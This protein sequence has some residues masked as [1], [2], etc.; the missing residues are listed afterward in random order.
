MEMVMMNEGLKGRVVDMAGVVSVYV[1]WIQHLL[2][3]RDESDL[4]SEVEQQVEEVP[5]SVPRRQ[6]AKLVGLQDHQWHRLERSVSQLRK[7]AA[8]QVQ[9]VY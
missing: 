5:K 7:H 9:V 1:E 4:P 6:P 3:N 8:T 2:P